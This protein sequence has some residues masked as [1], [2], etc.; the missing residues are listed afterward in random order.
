MGLLDAPSASSASTSSSRPRQPG[1]SFGEGRALP[2]RRTLTSGMSPGAARRRPES[3]PRITASRSASSGS[4]TSMATT[5]G[6]LARW[7]R[8]SLGSLADRQALPPPAARRRDASVSPTTEPTLVGAERAQQLPDAADR[9]LS[10]PSPRSH[11]PG[12]CRRRRPDP[13]H[14][15]AHHHGAGPAILEPDRLQA[16]SRGNRGPMRP[17]VA[18][19]AATRSI[20]AAG[21]TSTRL[22]GPNTAMPNARPEASRARP[23]S[24]DR[25]KLA[26]SSI[27][28][29]M[30][31]P[32]M[33]RHARARD[34]DTTP[35]AAAGPRLHA[36]RP[37]LQARRA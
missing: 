30:S 23:P 10:V 21:M 26:S 4:S 36:R 3:P 34:P 22:R 31:P 33:L 16:Q 25:R 29:S 8:S 35:R 17:C 20:V 6:S 9:L 28:A 15:D 19:R 5:I 18:S 11:R 1:V 2:A 12:G 14:V 32:R 13:R 24:L 37:P 7:P 27:R